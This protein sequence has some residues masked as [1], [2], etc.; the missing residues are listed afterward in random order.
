M[1]I[2][3]EGTAHRTAIAAY[4]LGCRV[5]ALFQLAFNGAPPADALFQCLL[6]VAVGLI[7]G[8]GGFAELVKVAPLVGDIWHGLFDGTADRG[9]TIGDDA[10][11]GHA[12]RLPYRVHQ[13]RQV[14]LRGGQQAASQEDL[15]GATIAQDPQHLMPTSG[16]KPSRARMTRPWAWVIC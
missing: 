13:G 14:V 6:G 16:C 5:R 11:N 15:C 2:V 1:P 12:Q 3:G 9:L 10:H 4:D 7:D 8:L